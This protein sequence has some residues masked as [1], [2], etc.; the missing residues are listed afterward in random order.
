MVKNTERK[1]KNKKI[2]IAL[3]EYVI[4]LGCLLVA[5]VM[6]TGKERVKQAN[7]YAKPEEEIEYRIEE[8]GYRTFDKWT[9]E[10]TVNFEVEEVQEGWDENWNYN[11]NAKIVFGYTGE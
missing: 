4:T 6:M 10:Q 5:F 9:S 2:G 7:S 8:L 3:M 1:I 11:C